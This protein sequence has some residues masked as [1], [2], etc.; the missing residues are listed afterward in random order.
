LYK[1]IIFASKVERMKKT[2]L[3]LCLSI[4]LLSGCNDGDFDVPAFEFTE[5]LHTCGTYVLYRTSASN[6]E[7]IIMT[8]SSSSLPKIS[9]EKTLDLTETNSV[10]YR[11]FSEAIGSNYFCQ[12]IP[13][14]EP[15]ILKEL[16]ASGGTIRIVT[17][18]ILSNGTLSGYAHTVRV[19]NL[20]FADG[21]ERI[22]FET[23]LFG[24]LEV[25]L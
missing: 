2:I 15:Y 3:L 24:T 8:L 22:L 25:A 1:T 6:T 10:S 17:E 5:E 9:G 4:G 20:I 21:E 12:D 7:A 11:I 14:V 18:E 13:P 23:F 19:E 16:H